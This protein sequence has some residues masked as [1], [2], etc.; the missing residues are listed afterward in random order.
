MDSSHTA[1]LLLLCRHVTRRD[2][3]VLLGATESEAMEP[4]ELGAVAETLEETLVHERVRIT[5]IRHAGSRI[6]TTHAQW[7]RR[8]LSNVSDPPLVAT[9]T[10]ENLAPN[11][12]MSW[13]G[14]EPVDKL[15]ATLIHLNG[16]AEARN[17]QR[18]AVLVVGHM[19]QLGWLGARL[20][21]NRSLFASVAN[22]YVPP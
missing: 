14:P 3:Q 6:A 10:P 18:R 11:H 21:T 1:D 20:M 13:D 15:L 8:R 12:F 17:G 4:E 9:T 16:A 2:E 5:A 7:L 22:G 19:P